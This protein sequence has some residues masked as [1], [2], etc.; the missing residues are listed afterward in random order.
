MP[1]KPTYMMVLVLHR[2]EIFLKM[3]KLIPDKTPCPEISIKQR[4]DLKNKD[5]ISS[6]KRNKF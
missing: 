6:E 3:V 2:I 5:D 4:N 1:I